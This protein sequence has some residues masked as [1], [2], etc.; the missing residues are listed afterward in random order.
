MIKNLSFHISKIRCIKF[1]TNSNRIATCGDD[2]KIDIYSTSNLS[3]PL[4]TILRNGH[5]NKLNDLSW[6][7]FQNKTYLSSC[8]EDQ[9][10]II[11][12]LEKKQNLFKNIYEYKQHNF[13]VT[14]CEFSPFHYGLILLCGDQK[15]KISLHQFKTDINNFVSHIFQTGHSSINSLSWGPAL[16]PIHF[17][18][19]NIDIDNDD[20]LQR[21]N[22]YQF[23]SCGNE[24]S[25]KIWKSLNSDINNFVAE[26]IYNQ[27]NNFNNNNINNNNFNNNNFNNNNFN[28]NNFNSQNLNNEINNNKNNIYSVKWL[29]YD[30]Y[31]DDVIV[32]GGENK[33]LMF[34]KYEE[35]E[36][37]EEKW[38]KV[39]EIKMNDCISSIEM[40]MK[41][42]YLIVT[43]LNNE[44]VILEE[45]LGFEWIIKNK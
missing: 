16:K 12:F 33:K 19:N 2:G 30:G 44:V 7:K 20:N 6:S 18:V 43:L 36:E 37:N 28:D 8:G 5:F 39:F 1:D 24:G 25:V 32:F 13:P 34:Y 22:S 45:N 10:K 15:G 14:K 41:G 27:N 21:L 29:N 35:D 40:S 42:G 9:N 38:K 31:C 23:C 26:D 11:I 3:K 17:N 4:T